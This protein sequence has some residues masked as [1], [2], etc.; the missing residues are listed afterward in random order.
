[1]FIVLQVYKSSLPTALLKKDFM[2]VVTLT[3]IGKATATDEIKFHDSQIAIGWQN[4]LKF[5]AQCERLASKAAWWALLQRYN[6]DFDLRRFDD[7]NGGRDETNK[8]ISNAVPA[9]SLTGESSYVASILPALVS[10]LSNSIDDIYLIHTLVVRFVTAFGLSADF[11]AQKIIEFFLSPLP[12][13]DEVGGTNAERLSYLGGSLVEVKRDARSSIRRC[14]EAARAVLFLLKSPVQRAA[15]LRRCFTSF[16]ASLKCGHDYDRLSL[17]LSLYQNELGQAFRSCQNS[18]TLNLYKQE[19]EIIHRRRDALTILSSFF[20]DKRKQLRPCFYGFF[21]ALPVP[22]DRELDGRSQQHV[23]VLGAD[24]S[25]KFDPLKPLE[26]F[27]TNH[28]DTASASG[29]APLC[30]PLGIPAG[31]I[32]ARALMWRFR[33]SCNSDVPAPTFEGDVLPVL[34]KIRSA[35]DQTRLAEWC[36]HFFIKQ[37]LDM[38]ACLESALESAIMAS[39]EA[40]ASRQSSPTDKNC[41]ALERQALET[42]KRICLRKNALSDKVEIKKI[43]RSG[44]PDLKDKYSVVSS[45]LDQLVFQLDEIWYENESSPETLVD[46]LLEKGSLLAANACLSD[47][48]TLTMGDLRAMSCLVKR[49]CDAVA[50]QHSHVH[51][52]RISRILAER[53]L[54]HGDQSP[55]DVSP[56]TRPVPIDESTTLRND[57][58]SSTHGEDDDTVNFVMDLANLRDDQAIWGSQSISVQQK[59]KFTSDEE[60]AILDDNGSSREESELLSRRAAI[61]IAFVL[62]FAED[63]PVVGGDENLHNAMKPTRSKEVRFGLLPLAGTH[64]EARRCNTFCKELLSIVFA[65]EDRQHGMTDISNLSDSRS[66]ATSSKRD[67]QKTITFAMK[68]RALRVASILCPQDAL[69]QC[70]RE[71]EFVGAVHCSLRK[72]TFGAFVAKEVEEMKLSLP[73]SDL[74]HLSEMHHPTYARTLWR[75]HRCGGSEGNKGRLLLLLVEMSVRDERSVDTGFLA[76]ILNELVRSKLPRSTILTCECLL[77][78]M[79][80]LGTYESN[81]DVWNALMEA[82]EFASGAIFAELH[83]VSTANEKKYFESGARTARRLCKLFR[84]LNEKHPDGQRA[85]RQFVVNMAGVVNASHDAT[86]SANAATIAI[87]AIGKVDDKDQREKFGAEILCGCSVRDPDQLASHK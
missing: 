53:W 12:D 47:I 22:F 14:E 43:L 79:G 82:M 20:R 28:S 57:S 27:F 19:L 84:K 55:N 62:A 36:S 69:E 83:R 80:K 8:S 70:M 74:V 46:F 9:R 33:N 11:A 63:D 13:K 18:N 66:E 76:T 37:D 85:L 59:L 31:Y 5:K 54:V 49:A 23:D 10:T 71:E 38:L 35:S 21:P 39:K 25:G 52:C 24:E 65:Q 75:H 29:L 32:H 77:H 26:G 51:T 17:V 78:E 72:C 44:C 45:I 30:F 81:P 56:T 40:E 50:E 42:V 64:F 7:E 15:V 67:L 4:Q 86:F 41:V 68:H 1:M 87:D 61:R 2:R 34:N 3:N 6:V 73:H 60:P 16:E 48:A 58:F